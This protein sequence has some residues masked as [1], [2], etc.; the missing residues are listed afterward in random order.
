[1]EPSELTTEPPDLPDKSLEE[2]LESRLLPEELQVLQELEPINQQEV[3]T[4]EL[5]EE[6]STTMLVRVD[7]L[8]ELHQ[9][10]TPKEKL[11]QELE[12][13][14]EL[15]LQDM[16]RSSKEVREVVNTLLKVELVFQPKEE[17]ISTRQDQNMLLTKEELFQ[18]QDIKDQRP[19]ELLLREDVLLENQSSQLSQQFRLSQE[20]FRIQLREDLSEVIHKLFLLQS[21]MVLNKPRLLLKETPFPTQQLVDLSEETHKWCLLWVRRLNNRLRLQFLTKEQLVRPLTMLSMDQFLE[22]HKSTME[23][24]LTKPLTLKM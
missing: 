5:R 14:E 6:L 11:T 20:P 22:I 2:I 17:L 7:P 9:E 16:E 13:E 8:E 12:L 4:L 23:L 24:E 3:S 15:S 19:L 21:I 18:A 10:L 1:M